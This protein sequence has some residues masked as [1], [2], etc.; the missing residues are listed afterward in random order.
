M[1]ERGVVHRDIKPQN[2]LVTGGRVRIVDFGIARGPETA[3]MTAPG[4][5]MGTAQYLAPEVIAGQPAT[6]RSDLYSLGVVLYRLFTGRLP[7][8]GDD[9]FAIARQHQTAEVPA[10]S[11][12]VP[13]L[14]P[15][16]EEVLLRLLE[17]EPEHRYAS[18]AAA[19]A[20]LAGA[21]LQQQPA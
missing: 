15:A 6:P 20:A 10:P 18:A 4:W 9:P 13:D 8:E 17:K 11:S 2:I 21:G 3:E 12:I 19:G 5:V 14:P 16:L 7:F 1:H